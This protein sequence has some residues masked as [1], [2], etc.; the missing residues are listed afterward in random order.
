[1]TT[2][3]AGSTHADKT[4]LLQLHVSEYQAIVARNSV[5]QSMQAGFVP[6]LLVFYALIAQLWS[7][8]DH[9]VLAWLSLLVFELVSFV[10][11]QTTLEVYDNVRYV[12]TVLRP[13]LKNLLGTDAFWMYERWVR[14]R[15]LKFAFWYE[16][17]PTIL[18]LP[19]LGVTSAWRYGE[20]ALGDWLAFATCIVLYLLLVLL[21]IR[22]VRTRR[23]FQRAV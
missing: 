18:T 8:V 3:T 22:M 4:D 20:R 13:A 9:A 15:R 19:A 2:D 14:P 7:T 12:E 11:G 16:A 1:M 10:F 6:L 17:L 21:N 5:W 23:E